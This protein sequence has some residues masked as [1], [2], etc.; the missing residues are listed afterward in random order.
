[1]KNKEPRRAIRD[2]NG[3]FVDAN[4]YVCQ[5]GRDEM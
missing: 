2:E 3:N 1:M 5:E 4:T